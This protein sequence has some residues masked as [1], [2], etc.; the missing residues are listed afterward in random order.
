M[1]SL[2]FVYNAKSDYWSKKIDFAHKII[3][4]STYNCDLCT[5][6]HGNWG[7][8]EVWKKFRKNEFEKFYPEI[9]VEF[10]VI[11]KVEN[12]D[13][14]SIFMNAESLAKIKTIEDLISKINTAF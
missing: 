2:L 5:L 4:P 13:E 9:K 6:T 14:T 7:E 11:L 1:K 10:P 8:T 12:N 3:S